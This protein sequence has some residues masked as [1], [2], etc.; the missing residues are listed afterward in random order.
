[1]STT[2]KRVAL[3]A[4]AALGLGVLSVAPS[5]AAN[6][7]DTLVLSSTTAT[8]ETGDTATATSASTTAIR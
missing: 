2:I 3:V 7:G 6:Q 8:Q 4:V 1:M 5:T